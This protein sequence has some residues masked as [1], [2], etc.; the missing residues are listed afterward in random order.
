MKAEALQVPVRYRAPWLVAAA[1]AAAEGLP[2]RDMTL[3]SRE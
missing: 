2:L 1:L 3:G